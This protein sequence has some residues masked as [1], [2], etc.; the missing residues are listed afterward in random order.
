MEENE[1][2]RRFHDAARELERRGEHASLRGVRREAGGGSMT[3]VAAAM[4]AYR[5]RA[6]PPTSPRDGPDEAMLSAV[7]ALHNQAQEEALA[8][9]ARERAAL[10]AAQ[11]EVAA[12]RDELQELAGDIET[13]RDRALARAAFVEEE[14]E[15]LKSE[16]AFEKGRN[17]VLKGLRAAG[18]VAKKASATETRSSRRTEGKGRND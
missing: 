7:R 11:A 1:R 10:T 4:R 9:V 3:D 13:E 14:N 8:L 12:F 6:I 16:L 15:Q 2:F 17:A 18:V 5:E